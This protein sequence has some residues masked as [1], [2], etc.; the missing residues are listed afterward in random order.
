MIHAIQGGL[1]GVYLLAMGVFAI[2]IVVLV[3][4]DLTNWLRGRPVARQL[5]GEGRQH[6]TR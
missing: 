6:E 4:C 3:V 2:I 5:Y 1:L